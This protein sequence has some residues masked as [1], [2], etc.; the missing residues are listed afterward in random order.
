[1]RQRAGANARAGTGDVSE[2]AAGGRHALEVTALV[3]LGGGVAMLLVPAIL[4]VVA[5][6]GR[7]ISSPDVSVDYVK[8]VVWAVALG[9]SIAAWPVTP[10]ERRAL[11]GMWGV[12]CLV[13]LG[14]MLLYEWNYAALDAYWYFQSSQEPR[15][16]WSEL[17]IGSDA[18]GTRMIQAL[19]WLHARWLPSSYH[20]L[21]VTWSMIGLVG[22]FVLYRAACLVIGERR[23]AVFVALACVPSILFWSSILGKDPIAL[24]GIALVTYGLT[25]VFHGRRK[26]GA[27]AVLVGLPIAMAIRSWLG[28]ILLLPL[29]AVA[30]ASVRGVGR[31]LLVVICCAILGGTL[32][33]ALRD[34]IALETLSESLDLLQTTSQAWAEGGS[35]QTLAANLSNPVELL[36]FIPLGVVTALFRPLPGEVMNA[37]GALAGLENLVVLCLL[38]VAIRRARWRDL[39][40][41]ILLW[42]TAFIL[43]WAV[44][45]G[46]ISYQNLGTAVRFRLQV[47]P[48][49]LLLLAY[50][51]RARR[52]VREAGRDDQAGRERTPI[53]ARYTSA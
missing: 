48:A 12:K 4:A 7:N 11:W 2:R 29:A 50:L 41:P 37:F 42:A 23:P 31:K 9:L 17:R 40:D 16:E 47:L 15:Y 53:A 34:R 30:V 21:K 52:D 25:A 39:A 20:A 14:F 22:I 43:L 32:L 24:L 46:P 28:P 1:M 44:V 19:A 3:A 49:M 33:F 10:A 38:A 36:K 5:A 6:L 51:A 27:L 35:A 13:T 8:G 18:G 45:Y 26:R